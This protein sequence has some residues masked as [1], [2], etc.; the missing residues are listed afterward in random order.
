MLVLDKGDSGKNARSGL[1]LVLF[2][3]FV[4]FLFLRDIAIF[5]GFFFLIVVVIIFVVRD[6]VQVH[7]MRL[8]NLELGFAFG[9][10][11]DFAF[12]DFVFVHIDFGGTLRAADHGSILR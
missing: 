2:F 7:G 6:E 8:R 9:A 5:C 3:L 12:F 10:A 11:Q 4:F 1:L